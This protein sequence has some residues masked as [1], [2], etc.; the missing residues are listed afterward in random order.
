M[1]RPQ[2]MLPVHWLCFQCKQTLSNVTCS[3]VVVSMFVC[4][5]TIRKR[6]CGKVMLLHLSVS[7]SV[8][9]RGVYPSMHWADTSWQ[10]PPCG[11]TPRRPGLP[12]DRHPPRADTSQAETPPAEG[13]CGGR[14]ASY[15]NAFLLISV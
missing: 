15:W 8:H 10:T 2:A 1:N 7:H 13:Y 6:S 11:Q 4:F 3:S 5:I 12:L 14:Y 9:G